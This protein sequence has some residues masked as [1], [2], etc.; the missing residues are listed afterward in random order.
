MKILRI[1]SDLYPYVVGGLGLHTH[2]LSRLQA[3]MGHDVTVY[4]SKKDGKL[5]S[6]SVDGYKIQSF[7]PSVQLFGNS[8][9]PNMFYYLMKNRN[10]F[11][12]LH[13]HSHLFFSTNMSAAVKKMGAPPLVI[14]NHGLISQSAPKWLSDIY[15]PTV[16]KWTFDMAS[17]ILCYTDSEKEQL[18]SIG[19]S[20]NKIAVI[21]NGIDTDQFSPSDEDRSKFQI[22]WVGRF[23]P[24]K[25]VEYL[26]DAFAKIKR[27]Y[28]NIKLLMIGTGPLKNDVIK[29]IEA[30]DL[31]GNVIIKD[32]VPNSE[33]PELYR[34]SDLFVLPSLEEG[35]P[36]TI[37]EAMACGVPVVCTNLPQL[38]KIVKDCGI[39]VP[40]KD[41]EALATSIEDIL[42]NIPKKKMLGQNGRERVVKNYSWNDTVI[43]TVELY[44]C[45]I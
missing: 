1:T 19:V 40:V 13:A 11:D 21:H 4:I 17:K 43:K 20:S 35:V 27:N 18:E 45:L 29:Q 24:G 2:Y 31:S 16:A 41:S 23:V 22:L 12:I 3:Q 7:K 36:R 30:L 34:N 38:D 15:T 6:K 39:V 42:S 26:I 25:G 8:I 33:I 32:F 37:L 28:Y 10:N 44:K 9:M 14:T 5:I